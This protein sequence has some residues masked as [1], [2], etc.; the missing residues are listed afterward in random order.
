MGIPEGLAGSVSGGRWTPNAANMNFFEATVDKADR[1]GLRIV[2]V[3][4]NALNNSAWTDEQHRL[5]LGQYVEHVSSRVGAEVDLWQVYNEHDGRDF[6][7]YA[8]VTLTPEYMNRLRLALLQART[9]LRKYS[10]APLTT[11]AFG[12][13]VNQARYDK[14]RTFFDGIGSSLDVI[15]LHAYPE[16]SAS[17][18]S[19]VPSYMR[20]LR[21]RYGKPV[22]MLEF[23]L[24][25]VSGYGTAQQVGQAIVDQTRAVM[26]AEPFCATLYQLRDRGTN[27]ND[28]EQR[29]GVLTNNWSRKS[30]YDP[31]VAEVRRWRG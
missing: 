11:T 5:Y 25:D 23:G 18:I 17:V 30:Y 1:A 20:Q 24:P 22:A 26:S 27:I 19:L 16:K 3:L 9:S 6:R 10:V 29:F 13:P 2:L 7:S 15:G 4:A 28:G 12:Y 21:Q 14:W 31:V 8:P